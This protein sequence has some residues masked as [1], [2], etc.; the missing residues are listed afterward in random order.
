MQRGESVSD[1]QDSL[2]FHR[3]SGRQIRHTVGATGPHAMIRSPDVAEQFTAAIDHLRVLSETGSGVD[4]AQNLHYPIHA[5]QTAQYRSY[6]GQDV[7]T[8]LAGG[9]ASFLN[10]QVGTDLTGDQG[11]VHPYGQVS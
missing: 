3:H 1:F 9:R 8:R 11:S 7:K 5:V 6:G 4:H 2:D 10:R